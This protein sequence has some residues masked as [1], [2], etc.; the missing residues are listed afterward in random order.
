MLKINTKGK[1]QTM[2]L[3]MSMENILLVIIS[4]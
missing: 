3:I 1:K 2:K 4:A